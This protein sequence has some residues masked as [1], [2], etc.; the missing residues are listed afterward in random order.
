V[1]SNEGY[2]VEWGPASGAWDSY[3]NSATTATD[4]ENYTATGLTRGA[5]YYWRCAALVG[6][7]PQTASNEAS[8]VAGDRPATIG[9]FRA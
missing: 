6:G 9:W 4:T 5:T 3:A 7:T 8:F 2:K 1:A